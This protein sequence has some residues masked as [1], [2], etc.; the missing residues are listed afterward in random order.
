MN[1]RVPAQEIA[2]GADVRVSK[3]V[4]M[5]GGIYL[6]KICPVPLCGYRN[7]PIEI[8]FDQREVALGETLLL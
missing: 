4:A 1:I 8:S 5:A 3:V 2:K 7:S 6:S